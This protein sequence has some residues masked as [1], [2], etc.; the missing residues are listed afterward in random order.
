VAEISD[1]WL[2]T[3]EQVSTPWPDGANPLLAPGLAARTP[4]GEALP[5]L[6]ALVS[7]VAGRPVGPGRLLRDIRDDVARVLDV[8]L[9]VPVM[10]ARGSTPLDPRGGPNSIREP[11]L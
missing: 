7:A 2:R 1:A 4:V 9:E 11:A 6:S 5:G 8:E 3:W 10:N